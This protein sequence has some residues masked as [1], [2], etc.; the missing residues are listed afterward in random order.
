MQ[1]LQQEIISQYLEDMPIG[2]PPKKE[3]SK[4]AAKIELAKKYTTE[5]IQHLE[6]EYYNRN[7]L[8]SDLS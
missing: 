1:L 3:Q 4:W 6:Y 8:I 2:R 7:R 5:Q